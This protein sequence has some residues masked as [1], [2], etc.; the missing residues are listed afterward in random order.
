LFFKKRLFLRPVY[1]ILPNVL[2]YYPKNYLIEK[3]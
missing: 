3:G 2:P 1:T